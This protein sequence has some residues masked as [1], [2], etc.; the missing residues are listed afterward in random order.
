MISK[1]SVV[2]AILFTVQLV[3]INAYAQTST[4]DSPFERRF[5]DVKFLDAYFGTDQE[6]IE[7]DHGDKNVPFTVVLANVG[8]Q[9]ITGIKGQLS[10][11]SGFTPADGKGSLILADNDNTALAGAVFTLTFFVN[12]DDNTEIRQYPSTIK[13]EYSIIRE[14]GQRE[15]FFDFNFKVTGKSV[16]NLKAV[17][18]VLISIKNN[19]VVVEVSN[20]G[21]APISNVDIV[22]QNTQISVATTREPITNLE[23]VVFDQSHWDIGTIEPKSTK[24]FAFN[25]YVPEKLKDDELHTPLEITYSNAHGDKKTVKTTVDFYINGLVD[26]SIFGV[27]VIDLSGKQIVIGEV[28][29]EG[30]VNGLFAFV[31]LEPLGNSNIKKS[32][33]YIDE[34]EPDSPV[35][36][37]IPVEFDGESKSGAHDVRLTVRYKDSLRNENTITYDTTI[38]LKDVS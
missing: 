27:D 30:N 1:L 38:F 37:N 20:L 22:L 21:T 23:N 16:L 9:D 24:H 6:K 15:S 7:V 14:Y 36:F 8:S 3:F 5:T 32:T 11:P 28:L 13:V 31:T 4:S 18:P 34:L 29:N 33:Q 12:V 10:L 19:P 25:V 26:A 35:P 2:V 17:D